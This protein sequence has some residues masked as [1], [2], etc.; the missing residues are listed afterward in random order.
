M[1]LHGVGSVCLPMTGGSATASSQTGAHPRLQYLNEI[2]PRHV[3]PNN[4]CASLFYKV[5]DYCFEVS[6]VFFGYFALAFVAGA[7]VDDAFD[8][9]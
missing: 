7:V 6:V 2:H 9:G 8:V 5:E 1:V 4:L 3:I